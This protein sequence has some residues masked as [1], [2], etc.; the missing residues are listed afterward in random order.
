M[1][2]HLI[3]DLGQKSGK[4]E[5]SEATPILCLVGERGYLEHGGEDS[6]RTFM[7]MRR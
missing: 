1:L 5:R 3:G 4:L 6:C 2:G 7:T